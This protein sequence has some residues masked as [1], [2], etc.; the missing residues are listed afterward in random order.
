MSSTNTAPWIAACIQ[1]KIKWQC[2]CMHICCMAFIA[3]HTQRQR[4]RVWWWPPVVPPCQ[5]GVISWGGTWPF[6]LGFATMAGNQV[7]GMVVRTDDDMD[8]KPNSRFHVL[9]TKSWGGGGRRQWSLEVKGL[10]P[11]QCISFRRTWLAARSV[12]LFGLIYGSMYVW[13]CTPLDGLT[14]GRINL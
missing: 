9:A 2:P 11:T 1:I 6:L 7:H 5:L 12:A 10:L 3:T 13:L 14:S 4:E 8:L